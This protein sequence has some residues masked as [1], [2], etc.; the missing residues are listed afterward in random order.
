V[1]G[2]VTKFDIIKIIGKQM[3]EYISETGNSFKEDLID[4]RCNDLLEEILLHVET[5]EQ[6]KKVG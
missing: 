6:S 5:I 3:G 1:A 4:A 2:G